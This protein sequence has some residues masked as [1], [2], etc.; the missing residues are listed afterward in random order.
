MEMIEHKVI[1]ILIDKL[2][3]IFKFY[4]D[5]EMLVIKKFSILN[6]KYYG[7]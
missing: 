4:I 6:Y 5:Y 3:D 2:Q 1:C 7:T